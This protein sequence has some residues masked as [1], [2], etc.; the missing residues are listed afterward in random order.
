MRLRIASWNVNSVRLRADQI[1]RFAR[2]QAPDVLCMQ[3][4]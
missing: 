4:I 2:E 1:I 3:E